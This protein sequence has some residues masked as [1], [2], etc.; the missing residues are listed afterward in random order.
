MSFIQQLMKAHKKDKQ[1]IASHMLANEMRA[2]KR[3]E[4][5][6]RSISSMLKTGLE[7]LIPGVGHVLGAGVDKLGRSLGQG[8]DASDITLGKK[9]Q[10]F[11]GKKAL[12]T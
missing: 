6:W 11:G 4:R 1:S 5:G 2:E 8:G 10:V 7:T 9:Y 12:E 3:K